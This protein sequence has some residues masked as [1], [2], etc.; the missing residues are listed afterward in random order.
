ML[1][2]VIA[3]LLRGRAVPLLAAAP[4]VAVAVGVGG[5]GRSV[6]CTVAAVDLGDTQ[7]SLLRRCPLR[8]ATG[9]VVVLV[10]AGAPLIDAAGRGIVGEAAAHRRALHPR[11]SLRRG[12]PAVALALVV[13]LS[14]FAL[15]SGGLCSLC[16]SAV[17]GT[18]RRRGR[19]GLTTG[20]GGK[21]LRSANNTAARQLSLLAIG[22]LR[23]ERHELVEN[24]QQLGLS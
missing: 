24:M 21:R 8:V 15:G 10:A 5:G 2:H 6:G 12:A 17:L 13:L 16:V 7:Q 22:N 19:V 23:F 14:I 9:T 18:L 4:T 20:V 11:R 1:Q 3:Y